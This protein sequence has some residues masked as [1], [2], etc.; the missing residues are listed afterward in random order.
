MI[1]IWIIFLETEKYYKKKIPPW[2]FRYKFLTKIC[3]AYECPKTNRT[4]ASR[5]CRRKTFSIFFS[6]KKKI[7]IKIF[8]SIFSSCNFLTWKWWKVMRIV[9]ARADETYYNKLSEING[10]WI[11]FFNIYPCIWVYS[12]LCVRR[13]VCVCMCVLVYI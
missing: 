5:K 2:H 13:Y 10:W 3:I 1:P 4:N 8:C 7:K 9:A 11:F 6:W 12:Y